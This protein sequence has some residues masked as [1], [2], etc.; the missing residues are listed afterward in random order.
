MVKNNPF[1]VDG[2]Q[3]NVSIFALLFRLIKNNILIMFGAKP[4]I[5]SFYLALVLSMTSMMLSAQVKGKLS[6]MVSDEDGRPLGGITVMLQ[7]DHK[8]V[9]SDQAGRFSIENL[10]PGTY[11][12]MATGMGMVTEAREVEILAGK[13]T[14]V[15]IMLKTHSNI[16]EEVQING[17]RVHADNVL[18]ASQSAQIVQ[19]ISKEKIAEMG[20]RRLD[21]VLREQT[22][23][24]VVSD[25][26][27]GNRS[28]GLQ[29]QGFS[30][31][32]I[33]VLINGQ[34]M[35]GRHSGNFDLSRISVADIE[36]IEVIKGASCSFYGS[37]ALG[38]TINIVTRQDIG[39]VQLT[40]AVTQGSYATTDA[41]MS[42][43]HPFA[44]SRGY[45]YLSGNYYCTDGFN[46]NPYLLSGSKTAPPYQSLSLQGRGR[47]RLNERSAVNL[48]GRYAGR[49]STMDRDYGAL[50]T[51]DV[52]DEQDLNAMLALENNLANGQRLISRYYFNRYASLQDVSLLQN[53][54][55]LQ[56]NNFTEYLHRGEVQ[57]SM[58]LRG[59]ELILS[60]G[61][62]G[63]Y[64]TTL[65]ET[66]G[67]GGN[68]LNYFGYTQAN[69]EPSARFSAVAGLRYDGNTLYGGRLNPTAGFQYRPA[70]WLALKASLGTGYKAPTYRQLYQR[71]TNLSQGYTVLGANSIREAIDELK[72]TGD[73][74]QVWTLG[75]QV[76]PL[77]PESSVSYNIQL[78]LKPAGSLE[79]GVNMFYNQIEN[80]IISQQIGIK[81]NGSQLFSWFNIA[82]MYSKG[83]EANLSWEAFKGFTVSAGYQ[84][85]NMKDRA[86]M[87][88]IRNK[89]GVYGMVRDLSGS[90]AA[91][92]SDYFGLVNRSRHMGNVQLNYHYEPLRINVSLRASYRGRYGFLDLDNNQYIDRYDVFVRG[93]ALLNASVQKKLMNDRMVVHLTADNLAGYTDYLMPNQPGRMVLAGITWIFYKQD[94][95]K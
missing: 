42:I 64:Q 50:P 16:L 2:L 24:A 38:G 47:Y 40:A 29:M 28:L 88:S 55:L 43:E 26:G 4:F 77:K 30:S 56:Q 91:T 83:I 36:R 82:E 10:Y 12:L 22:G 85:L 81:S 90:R 51:R 79:L 89:T 86:V 23:I 92:Q 94:Y 35:G 8:K 60:S 76:L 71:F 34:P 1:S 58:Q 52:L 62:G 75:A 25:L 63:E 14:E 44:A 46:V 31:E 84:W 48:T 3:A 87:D 95:K 13:V 69:W 45:G 66:D 20:S 61:T 39:A 68:M 17:M 32:Y 27:S 37:E 19:V 72:A 73:I 41:T 7:P 33:T 59:R 21:E 11:L 57:H 93:Y 49:S 18:S 80:L 78:T 74:E 53:G 54:K 67:A 65:A 70:T 9:V 5:F 6:G 15:S